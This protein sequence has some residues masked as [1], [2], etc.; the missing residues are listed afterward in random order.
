MQLK[1]SVKKNNPINIFVM[2]LIG[3]VV[4]ES[5][6]ETD[7]AIASIIEGQKGTQKETKR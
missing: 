7:S 1:R 6:N 2:Y 5:W 4:V 3:E